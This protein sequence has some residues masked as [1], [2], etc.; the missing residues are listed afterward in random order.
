MTLLIKQLT[1][2]NH[3]D[4][5]CINIRAFCREGFELHAAKQI[6]LQSNGSLAKPARAIFF[7]LLVLLLIVFQ[8]VQLFVFGLE[9]KGRS[10]EL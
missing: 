5:H 9:E 10:Y 7:F 6:F 1:V 3:L 4:N 8:S 2:Y